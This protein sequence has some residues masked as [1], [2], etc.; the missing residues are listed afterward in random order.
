MSSRL[1]LYCSWIDEWMSGCVAVQTF[2]TLE[3]YSIQQDQ[4]A[5]QRPPVRLL[6]Q[7]GQG[8]RQ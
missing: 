6:G 4:Q 8:C 3:T 7:Q 5:G 2:E 1:L